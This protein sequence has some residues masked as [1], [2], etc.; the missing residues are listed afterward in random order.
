[1]KISEEGLSVSLIGGLAMALS[2]FVGWTHWTTAA[3]PMDGT[4]RAVAGVRC[5]GAFTFADPDQMQKH[6]L[7][8]I[9]AA[10]ATVNERGLTAARPALEAAQAR[11]CAMLALSPQRGFG[12]IQLLSVS[13]EAAGDPGPRT[14]LYGLSQELAPFEMEALR[15]RVNFAMP[16]WSALSFEERVLLRQD[17]DIFARF[18]FDDRE[19]INLAHLG[20]LGGAAA[21]AELRELVMRYQPDSVRAFDNALRANQE[22]AR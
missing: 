11:I 22:R 21:A 6:V 9:N 2:A 4:A 12:W 10:A 19:A 15:A 18:P 17:A 16:R 1:L 5:P 8:E 20:A 3:G 13:P 7:E 14:A